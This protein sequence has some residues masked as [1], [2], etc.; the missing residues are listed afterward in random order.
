MMFLPRVCQLKDLE[1]VLQELWGGQ[2]DLEQRVR[3]RGCE[4][5]R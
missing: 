2:A 5:V 4:G 3:D 1:E